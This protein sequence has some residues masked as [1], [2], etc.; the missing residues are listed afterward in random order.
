MN[1]YQMTGTEFL[2]Y[3]KKIMAAIAP[4]L[5]HYMHCDKGGGITSEMTQEL[6]RGLL[7]GN[8]GGLR[9]ILKPLFTDDAFAAATRVAANDYWLL[10]ILSN[11]S[12]RLPQPTDANR[13]HMGIYSTRQ[14]VNVEQAVPPGSITWTAQDVAH[15]IAVG[16]LLLER[17]LVRPVRLIPNPLYQD[18]DV[19]RY[20]PMFAT[21]GSEFRFNTHNNKP[22]CWPWMT[23]E[24]ARAFALAQ[25]CEGDSLPGEAAVFDTVA[26]TLTQDMQ[27]P[28]ASKARWSQTEL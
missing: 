19:R 13:V 2:T 3:I 25:V 27:A 5:Q 7:T 11:V 28:S 6:T 16:A 4:N 23:F 10:R 18:D 24:E 8:E 15:P 26:R 17:K 12:F 21:R 9:E 20:S 22:P 1:R 14:E